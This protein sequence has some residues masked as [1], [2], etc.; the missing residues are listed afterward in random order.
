[1][2]QFA[3]GTDQ[4]EEIDEVDDAQA[5]TGDGVL[6]RLRDMPVGVNDPTIIGDAGPLDTPPGSD[7]PTE[8][9][10]PNVAGIPLP[11]DD[12]ELVPER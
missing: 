12:V 4:V 2:E 11:D 9:L 5:T 10:D 7:G 3:D 1:M 8:L 6:D